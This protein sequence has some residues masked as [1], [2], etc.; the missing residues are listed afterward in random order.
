MQDEPGGLLGYSE[1]AAHFVAANAITAVYEHPQRGKPLVQRDR[2]IFEDGAK[3][4]A[5]LLVAILALPPLLSLQVVVLFVTAG[6]AFRPV[7]P[8]E[9]GYGINA[10]LLIGEVANRLLECFG[11]VHA[12]RIAKPAW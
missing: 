11:L 8:A 9:G 1:S 12:Q 2:A 4:D 6:R 10:D 5:E 7:R 3:L